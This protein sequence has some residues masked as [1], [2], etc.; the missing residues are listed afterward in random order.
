MIFAYIA[1]AT[2]PCWRLGAA[3]ACSAHAHA[4]VLSG[5]VLSMHPAWVEVA[6]ENG[7]FHESSSCQDQFDLVL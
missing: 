5:S 4:P 2:D 3:D 1:C 6:Y 7:T